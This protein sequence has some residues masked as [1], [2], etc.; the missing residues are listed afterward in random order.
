M[1]NLLTPNDIDN[2]LL[3]RNKK[4][5]VRKLVD[6]FVKPVGAVTLGAGAAALKAL[7]RVRQADNV[8]TL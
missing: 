5:P 4:K 2:S 8:T 1:N 3:D 6:N 7:Q